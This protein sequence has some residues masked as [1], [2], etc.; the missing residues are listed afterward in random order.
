VV[1]TLEGR[2]VIQR[3][4]DR[5]VRW[6]CANLMRFNKAK[7]KV[8]HTGRGNP[9]HK[10]RLGKERTESSPEEKDLWVLADEKLNMTR[11]CALTVQM[12]NHTLGC[13]PSNVASKAREGI[14]PLC[15][16]L[17]KLPW[18]S[19][20]QLWSPQHRRDMDLLERVQRRSQK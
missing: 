13:I 10:H 12:A 6:A 7:R 8:L 5:L 15:S 18:K 11:Q 16:A 19:C 1:D 3:D 9:K 20:V 4:L 2:G 14:L 17:V